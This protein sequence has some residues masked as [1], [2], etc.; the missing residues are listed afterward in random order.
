[1]A[2]AVKRR[3]LLPCVW[4]LHAAA[5][6][7]GAAGSPED[8]FSVALMLQAAATGGGSSSVDEAAKMRQEAQQITDACVGASISEAWSSGFKDSVSQMLQKTRRSMQHGLAGVA[9]AVIA[10]VDGASKEC[11]RLDVFTRFKGQA[12]RLHV[13][14][15]SRSLASLD[16]KVKYEALKSLMVG[17]I[18]IHKELNALLVAWQMEKGPEAVGL[19][20]AVFLAQFADD[21]DA[22]PVITQAAARQSGAVDERATVPYWAAAMNE[23]FKRLGDASRP[24]SDACITVELAERQQGLVNAAFETMMQKSRRGMQQGLRTISADVVTLLDELSSKCESVRASSATAKLRTAASRLKVLSEAKNLL[25]PGVNVDYDPLKV[26]KVGGIDVHIELNRFIGAWTSKSS[27]VQFGDGLADFFEDFK[28]Q[29]EVA[30]AASEAPPEGGLP[31]MFRD[32]IAAADRGQPWDMDK[33]CFGAESMAIWADEMNAAIAN[34]LHKRK[35]TMQQ[36]LKEL[37]DATDKLI[38]S[39]G[40][41]C[42][43]GKGVNAI[44]SGARKLRRVTR[45]TVVDY[46]SHIKYEAMKS[47][48]VGGVAVH[49]QLNNFLAGWKLRSPDESGSAF[50]EL[51]LALSSVTGYDE[52]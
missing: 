33:T 23:A 27:A 17:D 13:L 40:V 11:G 10:L 39:Q 46:G 29:D 28:E 52:L 5:G 1:M 47:L 24:V 48:T 15:T 18:D 21:A 7:F 34:M 35:K 45:S 50:G 8:A 6:A 43:A 38:K 42:R 2:T 4:A 49:S 41:L 26:L 25:N 36:G 16:S 12:E 22:P 31:R 32:A 30:D 3:S 14:A 37:A 9:S 20:L 44:W 51:M 19:S